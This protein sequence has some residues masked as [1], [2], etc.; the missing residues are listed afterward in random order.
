MPPVIAVVYGTMDA[1]LAAANLATAAEAMG[2]G[3]CFVGAIQRKLDL[4]TEELGLPELVIPV[5]SLCVG[6]PDE[7]PPQIP[8]LP[9]EA[10]FHEN[11]YR[12]LSR[13]DLGRCFD[14]MDALTY[15]GGWLDYLRHFFTKGKEFERREV[16]WRRVLKRQGLDIDQWRSGR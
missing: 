14:A 2:Y 11:A 7:Q 1:V 16:M 13:A 4:L 5:V 15:F 8:R 10:V 9:T 3:I 6:I 12:E